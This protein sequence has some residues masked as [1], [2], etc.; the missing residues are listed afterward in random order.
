VL[1]LPTNYVYLQCIQVS[2]VD[3]YTCLHYAPKRVQLQQYMYKHKCK[4]RTK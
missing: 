4:N 2:S 3:F 1:K